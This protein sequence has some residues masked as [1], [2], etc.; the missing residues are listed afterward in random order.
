MNM[1]TGQLIKSYGVTTEV[2]K[3]LDQLDVLQFQ[4]LNKWMYE[5]GVARV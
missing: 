5:Q 1:N 2:F 4:Q 3:M